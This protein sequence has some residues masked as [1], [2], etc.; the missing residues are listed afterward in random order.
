MAKSK[1]SP[2]QE[3]ESFFESIIKKFKQSPG[4]YIGSVIILLLVVV[5]FLGGD[6]LSGGRFGTGGGDLTFGYYNKEPIS[7]V[8]GNYFSENYQSI[9]RYYQSQGVDINDLWTGAQIWRISFEGALTHTAVM[10]MVKR[11]NYSVP[12]RV[13]DRE[14]AMLSQ[15]QENGRFSPA[16]YRQASESTRLSLWRKEQESLAKMMFYNDFSDLLISKGEARFLANMASA[17]RTYEMVAFYVDD[18]PDSEYLSY[19]RDNAALFNSIHLSVI[20]VTSNEREARRILASV[21]DGTSTFEDAARNQSKDIYA[22]NGGDMGTRFFYELER[23]I[24]VA[25]NRDKVYN[26]RAG[27]MSDI[28]ETVSGWSFFRIESGAVQPDFNDEIVMERV[29]SYIRNFQRGRMED[30]AI[31][32]A[33]MY[34]SDVR[35]LGFADA[36]FSWALDIDTFG[37]IAMNFGNVDLFTSL[38]SFSVNSISSQDF[39]SMSR[40]ENFWKTIVSAQLNTPSEPLV[41]GSNVL[42]FIPTEE[43]ETDES[44]IN[45]IETMYTS[46]WLRYITEQ[47]IQQYFVNSDKTDDRFWDTYF[48]YLWSW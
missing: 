12:D 21:N 6:L 16:L 34:I 9:M 4:I 22:D 8:P 27:E 42:V 3:K 1:K 32:R 31:S 40:N 24:P 39:S 35:S 5:T 26:L 2:V 7:Y 43:A 18:Y 15:F 19:A 23:E 10:D 46:W 45:S 29:R 48:Q 28:I 41:Q 20:T 13:V 37:P 30:W 25:A 38:E 11:S 14:V 33:N 44:F 17:P 36:A 47:L